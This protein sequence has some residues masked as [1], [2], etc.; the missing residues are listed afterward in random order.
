[1][2][3]RNKFDELG[4]QRTKSHLEHSVPIV[5]VFPAPVCP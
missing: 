5:N 1:M 4:H 2:F 3:V